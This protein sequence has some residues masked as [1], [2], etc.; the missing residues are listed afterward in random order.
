MRFLLQLHSGTKTRDDPH[1]ALRL[2]L[3]ISTGV[4][5]LSICIGM[6]MGLRGIQLGHIVKVPKYKCRTPSRNSRLRELW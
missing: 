4:N 3:K 1:S 5:W 6:P 2:R